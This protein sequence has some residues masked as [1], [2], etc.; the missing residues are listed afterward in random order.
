MRISISP[1]LPTLTIREVVASATYS[2][3]KDNVE[4]S[5]ERGS[6]WFIH[7]WVVISRGEFTFLPETLSEG[8][9]EHLV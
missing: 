1:W 7:P 3:I 6:I 5:I 9:I 2:Q 8:N 4:F